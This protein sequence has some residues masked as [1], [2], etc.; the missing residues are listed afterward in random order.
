MHFFK[1][2]LIIMFLPQLFFGK[3]IWLPLGDLMFLNFLFKIFFLVIS[4]KIKYYDFLGGKKP[5]KNL[6]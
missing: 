4:P 2:F 3:N 5:S 6:N 1:P